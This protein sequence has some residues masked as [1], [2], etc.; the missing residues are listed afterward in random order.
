MAPIANL[1][2][3][4]S[5]QIAEFQSE[6]REATKS[7]QK[8]SGEFEGIAT[9][10]AA[11]GAFLG[12]IAAQIATSLATA[13]GQ[14]IKDA[15]RLSTEFSNAFLG[16]SSVAR[17]FGTDA[18]VAKDA[19]ARL[20]ADGLLPL[21]DSATG[22]KNL[23]AAGFNLDESTQLMNAFKDA[24]AFGRQGA[25]SFGDAVRTATEGVKNGNSILVDN[26]GITKNL[27]QILKEAG[28]SA[29]DLSRAS[30]DA[31]VRVALL[32]GI[33]KE[34]SAFAGDAA[35][36]TQTYAG[37]LTAM[38]TQWDLLLATWGDAITQNKAVSV[39]LQF[40][41]DGF[42][43]LATR[44]SDN[45]RGYELITDALIAFVTT[46][47]AGVRAMSFMTKAFQAI[48]SALVGTVKV[49]ADATA[50]IANMALRIAVLASKLPGGSSA[51]GLFRE[52]IVE[53]AKVSVE[54]GSASERMG[55]RI[56]ENTARSQSWGGALD[57]FAV[58]LDGLVVDLEAAR[59]K[60]IEFGEAGETAGGQLGDELAGG[61][62]KAAKKIQDYI[63][64]VSAAV[65]NSKSI[66]HGFG[67]DIGIPEI[68]ALARF[69]LSLAD[70]YAQ[71]V[72]LMRSG[73]QDLSFV[74]KELPG[75]LVE[76]T[77][78]KPLPP[79]FWKQVFGDTTSIGSAMGQSILSAIQ[80]GGNVFAAAAGSL[81]QSLTTKFASYLTGA[82][83]LG[84]K[85]IG[86]FL[87]GAINAVLPAVG[88]LLGPLV[89]KIT[90]VFAGLFNR[91]K[92]RD[93]VEAFADG[94][95][96]FNA[97]H[98]QLGTLG[99]AGERLWIQLTQG[100]G[101]NNPDQARKA[102]DAINQALSGQTDQFARAEA[103]IERWGFSFEELG[104]KVQHSRLTE[105]GK[106]LQQDFE[107]LMWIGVDTN[108]VLERM[109][110]ATSEFLHKAVATGFEVSASMRPMIEQM[111]D[112]G[113]LTDAA[114][115]RLQSLDDIP[116]AE[117][118][119]QS[120]DRVILKFDELIDKITRG[121]G[122]ALSGL[123]GVNIPIGGGGQPPSLVEGGN[124][125]TPT[126]ALSGGSGLSGGGSVSLSSAIVSPQASTS[127]VII[128][129]EGRTLAEV[130]VPHIPG[131]VQRYGLA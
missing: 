111:F 118:F 72:S 55:A 58:T 107:D 89:G 76:I 43:R 22:L 112:M 69:Q 36:L 117:T 44:L 33:L 91:N 32:N 90:D 49:F 53:L 85:A 41:A 66:G 61:V 67:A 37:T 20:S 1:T 121:V 57:G 56:A 93:M 80:G 113:L 40:V 48:D 35:K 12:T 96:G 122:G 130:L 100:V 84:G 27:S 102:I 129:A 59:G 127:T 29:Q 4:L 2:V 13:F 17:A 125:R 28:F 73:A 83:E 110:A 25:L 120:I 46:M 26:A 123:G 31:G 30:S 18:D 95:G 119:S 51:L 5:A 24:A 3:R 116:F 75:K 115:E 81:G 86:G 74:W 68:P 9:R 105:L 47:A 99:A 14:G 38:R 94:F 60:T 78:P 6:F 8:F 65:A 104:T 34:A 7:A 71:T 52:E 124:G 19:A 101:R 126:L 62:S 82:K 92:G 114:G 21:K 106:S 97:L 87:G 39:A 50:E 23:L 108:A 10:A 64:S 77:P 15:I 128:E 79:T 70:F 103:A 16:L 131:V 98:Q 11:V 54:A 63:R 88:S 42:G 45:G 109:S